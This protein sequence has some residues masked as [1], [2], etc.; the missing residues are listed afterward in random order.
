MIHEA[1][2]QRANRELVAKAIGECTYEELFEPAPRSHGFELEL[3]SGVAYRFEATRSPWTWLNV[4]PDSVRRDE[5]P[6]SSAVQLL[7]DAQTELGLDDVALGELIEEVQNTLYSETQRLERLEGYPASKLVDLPGP[8][9]QG[10]IDGHPKLLANKGRVGWGRSELAR[11][12]PESGRSFPLRYL[13]VERERCTIALGPDVT[14]EELVDECLDD[15]ARAQLDRRLAAEGIGLSTH[16]IVPVHPWQFDRYLVT[17]YGEDL[18]QGTIVDLG[19]LGDDYRPRQSI[20]TLANASRPGRMD[21]KVALTILNTSCYRG[22]PADT[23]ETGVRLAEWMGTLVDEDPLLSERELVVLPEHAGIHC[24]H[25]GQAQISDPPYR[26]EE[27]LGAVWRESAQAQTDPGQDAI[28][29]STLMQTDT[30][31]RALV[32]EYV[33]RSRLD[34]ETWLRRLF[35]ATTVPLY[36]LMCRYG[37]GLVAHGQ[38]VSLILEDHEPARGIVKDFHGDLRLVDREL[39]ELS[40]LDEETKD[41]LVRL[42]PS[43]LLQDLLTGHFVTTLRFVS[44]LVEDQLGVPEERFYEIAGEAIHDYQQAH[45]ELEDRFAMFDLMADELEKVLVN[46]ARFEAGFGRTSQRPKPTFGTPIEN[47]LV[48]GDP[49]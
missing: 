34:A 33:H 21:V 37:I 42:K 16:A 8:R 26:F 20:R 25:P 46:R 31:G 11:L 36:H 19:E 12:A 29:L 13:A 1:T 10:L 15:Q 39:P 43:H 27:M 6:A 24:P 38:N 18:A 4:D 5:K 22:I 3:A 7:V 14:L 47:P 17:Q 45:P 49:R 30:D 40:D 28:L 48:Q 44:P 9:L 32:A 2:W 41:A 35:E 23:L